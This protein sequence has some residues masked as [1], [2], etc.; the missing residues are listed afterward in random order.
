MRPP[1]TRLY[2]AALLL[3]TVGVLSAC[4]HPPKSGNHASSSA[5]E[6]ASPSADHNGGNH[7]DLASFDL[8]AH[9]G[10]RGE[11]TEESRQAFHTAIKEGV[12]TL[13]MDIVLTRDGIPAVW[14]DPQIKDE[15]CSDTHPATP[16]DPQFPYVGKNVH[17]LTWD[18]INT[19]TCN[20]K[21]KDF[22][23]QKVAPDNHILSL[24]EVFELVKHQG[25]DVRYNI[26]TK[27]EADKRDESATPEEFVTTIMEVI[28]HYDLR[29]KVTIQS[30]DWRSLKFL[31]EHHPNVPLAALYDET[32]WKK[33]SPW[34]SGYSYEKYNGDAL[35]A[36]Q[37]LGAQF[38]SPGYAQPYDTTVGN[39]DF[40]P[41][42]DRAY[43]EKAHGMNIKV[44][45]WTV[46]DAATMKYFIDNA[47]VD[48][49]I[50]DYP[51][52]AHDVINAL[53]Q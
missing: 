29:D 15:K 26:E 53:H 11:N 47:G 25:A 22:P 23:D 50:T 20:K 4:N 9:R 3:A 49:L 38:A 28:D 16:N 41:V 31:K 21:L 12:R 35:T 24:N 1:R 13:E 37:A 19:L 17:D 45:P 10:G 43:V 18:Q 34:L 36:I 14:H 44:L 6:T 46:N 33:N 32:T 27:I 8:Q 48:G 5:S 2:T 7:V 51:Q 30:F 39:K 52:R 42:A 40:H